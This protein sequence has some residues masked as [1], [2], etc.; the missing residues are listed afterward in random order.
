MSPRRLLASANSVDGVRPHRHLLAHAIVHEDE[1]REQRAQ[2][3]NRNQRV[4]KG[5]T[6]SPYSLLHDSVLVLSTFDGEPR[7]AT[8]S[9]PD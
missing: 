4:A 7:A 3:S 9:S 1:R 2:R 8:T 6:H 5:V